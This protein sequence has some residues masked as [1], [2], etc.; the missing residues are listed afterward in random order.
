MRDTGIRGR[1]AYGDPQGS[2]NDQVMDLADLARVKRE[3]MPNDGMLTLGVCS[4]NVGKDPNPLRGNVTTDMAKREWTA[5]RELGLPITLHTSGPSV[6]KLLEEAGL[7]GPDVQLVHPLLTDADDR[8]ILAKR[9]TSY[10]ASPIGELRR[11]VSAGETQIGELL[12]AGVRVSL[13][14]DHITTYDCDYFGIMRTAYSTH[15]HRFGN[16]SKVTSRRLVELA[17]IGGARDLGLADKI[18]SLTPGKRADLILIRT[19]DPNLAM[20]GGPFE[21]LVSL[22]QPT[23]VDTVVVDGRI[24]RRGGKFTSLDLAQ[25]VREAAEAARDLRARAGWPA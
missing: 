9:D 4:R 25:I 5:A 10:S 1:F 22:A 7:L 12:D 24:L 6:V 21:A 23:N 13:S 18:G 17:T 14:I 2:S 19:T 8:A 15:Q 11:P 20:M 16:R 3:W